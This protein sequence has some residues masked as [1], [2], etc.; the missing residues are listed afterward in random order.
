MAENQIRIYTHDPKGYFI[1]YYQSWF[2]HNALYLTYEVAIES[3]E[4]C[5]RVHKKLREVEVWNLLR[6]CCSSLE[7]LHK[8]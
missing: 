6:D 8:S 5:N 4:E 3:L 7:W 2:E 1:R